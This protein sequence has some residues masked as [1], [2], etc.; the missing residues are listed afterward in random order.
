LVTSIVSAATTR[1]QQSPFGFR[2][3]A[4]GA[5]AI[6]GLAVACFAGAQTPHVPPL[7][8]WAHREQFLQAR[9][10]ALPVPV[11]APEMPGKKTRESNAVASVRLIDEPSPSSSPRQAGNGARSPSIDPSTVGAGDAF[12]HS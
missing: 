8:Q 11:A 10:L 4:E 5:S 7:L 3:I 9:Q 1:V 12:V 6:D 2:G